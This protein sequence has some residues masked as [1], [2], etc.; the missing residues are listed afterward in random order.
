MGILVKN[1]GVGHELRLGPW[2]THIQAGQD[3]GGSTLSV[4]ARSA[5]ALRA[6]VLSAG[7]RMARARS[8]GARSAGARRALAR[9]GRGE[10]VRRMDRHWLPNMGPPHRMEANPGRHE[11]L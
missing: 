7:A 8:A 4:G 2:G 5:G 6:G 10:R 11:M 3:L 9:F 1:A